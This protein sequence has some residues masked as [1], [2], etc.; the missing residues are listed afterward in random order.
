MAL[1]NREPILKI[2]IAEAAL[3][4]VDEHI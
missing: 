2:E 3:A 1:P 4:F